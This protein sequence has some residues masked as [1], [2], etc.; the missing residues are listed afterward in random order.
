MTL[1][2]LECQNKGFYGSFGDFWLQHTFEEQ[3]APKSLETDWDSPR[4]KL[5]ASNVVFTSLNFASPFVQEFSTRGC[6][7]WVPPSK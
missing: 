4:I 6:Q 7:T 3:T 1:D 5:S 2:D